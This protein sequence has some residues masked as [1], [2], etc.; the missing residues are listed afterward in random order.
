MNISH[1]KNRNRMKHPLKT[2]PFTQQPLFIFYTLAPLDVS[3]IGICS[4]KYIY[5]V[6][7]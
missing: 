2:I 7:H 1:A 6:Q 5:Y 4:A 3:S